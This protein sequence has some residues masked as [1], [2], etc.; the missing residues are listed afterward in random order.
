MG[1][2]K[3]M[4]PT[5]IHVP[6]ISDCHAT[7]PELAADIVRFFNPSGRCLD[8]C[9][10]NGVFFDML[11]SGAEWCEILEGRDFYA[12]E[13]SAD[14]I[15]SNPPFSHY[16]EWI[17][18]S[19]KLAKDIV[20]LMPPYKIFASNKFQDELF[21][22]GGLVHIRRYGTGTDWGFP[23]GHALAAVHYQAEYTGATSWSKWLP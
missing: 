18:N 7:P 10:G 8:P 1:T 20:Y 4:Q 14:W 16:S 15:V 22:W 21:D 12:W 17:R 5:L 3:R 6:T 9:R 2:E 23:F 11:P 13:K 19:M